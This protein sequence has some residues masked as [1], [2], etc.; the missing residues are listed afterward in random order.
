MPAQ[1]ARSCGVRVSMLL[2]V[3]LLTASIAGCSGSEGQVIERWTLHTERA[4]RPIEM[5]VHLRELPKRAGQYRLSTELA[6]DPQ[7]RGRDLDLVIPYLPARSS[8]WVEGQPVRSTLPGDAP[9]APRHVGPHRWEIP[10]AAVLDDRLSLELHVTHTWTQSAWLDVPPRLVPSGAVTPVLERNR[11]LNDRGGWFGLIGLSQMGLTFLAVFFWDQRRRA[12]LWFAIQA[13]SASYYPAYVLGLTSGLGQKLE[14]VLLAESLCVATIISVYFTSEFFGRS[15]PHRA[16][17]VLLAASML[18]PTP[19][20][21]SEFLDSSYGTPGVIACVGATILY[22]IVTGTKLVFSYADRRIGIFFLCCWVALGS[23]AWVDLW[24]WSGGGEVLAGARPACIGLGLFG[25]F[26]SML[27]SRSHFRSLEE[28]DHLNLTLRGRLS[29]LEERKKEVEALN[30]ELRQQVGRR[31]AHILAALTQSDLPGRAPRLEAGSVVEGRYRVL[32]L[33]GAGGMGT[34]YEV[35]RLHDG[36]RLALK[37]THELRGVGLARLAREAQIATRVR[38]PNVVAVVDTDVATAGYV[39]L[40]MELVQGC[41][42][43]EIE[44]RRDLQW[45][46]AVLVQML[47]GIRALHTLGIIHRDLKP[48][49]VLLSGDIDQE[50]HVKVTDFGIS[51]GAGDA[52]GSASAAP[53]LATHEPAT[54]RISLPSAAHPSVRDVEHTPSANTPQLTRTGAIVGTPSYIAP[55][56]AA[57]GAEITPASD[58]F[59]FGVVAYRLLTGA[60]PHTEAPFLTRLDGREPVPHAPLVVTGLTRGAA[61]LLDACLAFSS[62]QRPT[63]SEL[64]AAL[65]EAL[66]ST[67]SRAGAS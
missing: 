19:A 59:S 30:E 10:H 22:Q 38:H 40:V 64:I 62:N 26:Q 44:G 28:A 3:A 58:I 37:M 41:S 7:L 66:E 63:A 67:A 55:E 53:L 18:V 5:P 61:R 27:L 12:Y 17:L 49:N 52:D 2:W 54:V 60:S 13:L 16:W 25:I 24:A 50:P 8:L 1:P 23:L 51:R 31:S 42:L 6:I 20:L 35:E 4:G 33:L 45:C 15:R 32:K 11:L 57:A 9:S 39:Y 56:L 34:V 47:E 14:T 43:A 21:F 48:A 65:G 46:L 36:R 29:D